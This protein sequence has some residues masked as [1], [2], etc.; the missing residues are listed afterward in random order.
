MDMSW[1]T[2]NLLKIS[3]D[4][5]LSQSDEDNDDDTEG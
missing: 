2:Y 5:K 3:C 4:Y 1:F